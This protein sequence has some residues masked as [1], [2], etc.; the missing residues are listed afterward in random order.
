MKCT[1]YK[2]LIY[3]IFICGY[4]KQ[5]WQFSYYRLRTSRCVCSRRKFLYRLT[6]RCTRGCLDLRLFLDRPTTLQQYQYNPTHRP[7]VCV[8]IGFV[9][10]YAGKTYRRNRNQSL[11]CRGP[12]GFCTIK[13]DYLTFTVISHQPLAFVPKQFL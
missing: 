10:F 6:I 1:N 2:L 4:L 11:W 8:V 7:H 13:I 12:R 5:K 3:E 9:W